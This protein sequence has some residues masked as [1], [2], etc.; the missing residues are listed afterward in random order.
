MYADLKP[1]KE[2][3]LKIRIF[4]SGHSN[5]SQDRGGFNEGK[6]SR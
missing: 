4:C 3:L 5:V 6:V 2:L 1:E